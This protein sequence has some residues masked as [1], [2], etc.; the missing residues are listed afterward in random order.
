MLGIGVR[1]LT[2]DVGAM[3]L[4]KI[5]AAHAI[6]KRMVLEERR[7][8]G[9]GIAPSGVGGNSDSIVDAPT[10][11]EEGNSSDASLQEQINQLERTLQRRDHE[12][13]IL[14]DMV[15][16]KGLAPR[17]SKQISHL[18]TEQRDDA[19]EIESSAANVTETLK[20]PPKAMVCGVERCNDQ[21]VLDE[22]SK[23]FD[24]FKER[25]PGVA[26]H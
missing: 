23:A 7:S 20:M 2:L 4:T 24:W 18:F 26:C 25:Y 15:K 5:Q 6:F 19:A 22:P 21:S 16:Q 3:T 11:R 10:H 17:A 14:V 1:V 9:G 13:A 12:I 8:A